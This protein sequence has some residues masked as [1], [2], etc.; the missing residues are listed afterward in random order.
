MYNGTL[1]KE[2]INF[3]DFHNGYSGGFYSFIENENGACVLEVDIYERYNEED[4]MD[5][6][7]HYVVVEESW[8]LRA[9]FQRCYDHEGNEVEVYDEED[10]E[11]TINNLVN[12]RG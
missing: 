9:E 7:G 11:E 3:E 10:I 5:L 1:Q 6:C 4:V 12:G 2:D 8:E